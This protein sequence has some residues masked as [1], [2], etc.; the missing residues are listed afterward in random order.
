MAPTRTR[1]RKDKTQSRQGGNAVHRP[2]SRP[3][4]AKVKA[5]APSSSKVKVEN[6]DAAYEVHTDDKQDE[7][8]VN[9]KQRPDA[10]KDDSAAHYQD[11]DEEGDES[12]HAS[13]SSD[14]E[15][16]ND[17][18]EDSSS[19]SSPPS[20]KSEGPK[21]S[22]GSKDEEK[23][24]LLVQK[25]CKQALSDAK[26]KKADKTRRRQTYV[27]LVLAREDTRVGCCSHEENNDAFLIMTRQRFDLFSREQKVR[28]CKNWGEVKDLGSDVYSAALDGYNDTQ[29]KKNYYGEWKDVKGMPRSRPL[30]GYFDFDGDDDF[31]CFP[32]FLLAEMGN[33][34]KHLNHSWLQKYDT[35]QARSFF[36]DF[37]P[38]VINANMKDLIL[39]EI[40][41]SNDVAEK[42]PGLYDAIMEEDEL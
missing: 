33:E 36:G 28:H 21:E 17:K 25:L 18:D 29:R 4:K 42:E 5:K 22:T 23:I 26:G 19:S 13:S 32:D 1:K 30:D 2:S 11:T 6:D 9:R 27:W 31:P 12:C 35:T 8:D 41:A 37:E 15:E 14:D 16:E 39:L 40:E 34:A 24:P 7:R 38:L 10:V 20:G 3:K